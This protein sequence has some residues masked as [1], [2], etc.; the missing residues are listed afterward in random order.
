VPEDER[1]CDV[2][3]TPLE[4]IGKEFLRREIEFIKPSIKIIDYY[5]VSYGCPKC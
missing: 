3:G 2:C 1:F 4:R 5:S